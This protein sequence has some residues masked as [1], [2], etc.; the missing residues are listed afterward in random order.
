MRQKKKILM[1][2]ALAF[3]TIVVTIAMLAIRQPFS[4]GRETYFEVL[5]G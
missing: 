4:Q 2:S 5:Y 1:M 3:A